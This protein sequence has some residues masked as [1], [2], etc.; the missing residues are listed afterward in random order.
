MLCPGLCIP[1]HYLQEA[2][3][4]A[5]GRILLPPLTDELRSIVEAERQKRAQSGSRWYAAWRD[6]TWWHIVDLLTGRV[7]EDEKGPVLISTELWRER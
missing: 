6:E 5:V 4:Q 1:L 3:L 7:I 2:T